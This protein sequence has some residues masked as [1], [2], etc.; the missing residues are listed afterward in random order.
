MLLSGVISLVAQA[1]IPVFEVTDIGI[2]GTTDIRN[3]YG[4][5]VAAADFDQD[6]DID[7]Y[8]A[9]INGVN[10][11]LYRNN[12]SGIFEDVAADVGIDNKASTSMALW[13]DYD[14]DH[15]LDLVTL[16]ERCGNFNCGQPILIKLFS[17][18]DD[19]TFIEVTSEAGLSFG[20]KYD[21]I[22]TS[23]AVGGMAAGDINNDGFLDL[24]VT[25]WGGKITMF[26]NNTD[27]TFTD[28]SES[29]GMG[30]QAWHYWQPMLYDFDHDGLTDIFCNVDFDKNQF[31][32][33]RGNNH[34][35]EIA[36]QIKAAVDFSEMGMTICD[37]DNDGD[38]DIYSTNITRFFEGRDEYNVLLRNDSETGL[39]SFT[40][41]AQSYGVA[42]SGWDW[43][44][45]FIDVN[46]DGWVDLAATNG[47][48]IDPR[49][50][51]D[52]S[53]FWL[54]NNG[55]FTEVTDEIKFN[56]E[57][58][59]TSLIA[60]D[61]DRDG[62]L[63]LL[64]TLKDN[65]DTKMP[66]M[67]YVNTLDQLSNKGNYVVIKPRM[68]GN[69]HFA[70]G[71]V[72]RVQTGELSQ[73]RL[74]SAG[75]SFYAQ[76]PAE[77]FFGMRDYTKADEVRIEWP[78]GEVSIYDDIEANQAITLNYEIVNAP[79][80]L[81]GTFVDDDLVLNWKDRADN[82]TGFLLQKS[83]S[84]DFEEYMEITLGSNTASY[85]DNA[86]DST[87]PYYRIKA[88]NDRVSSPFS[89][90]IHISP[91]TMVEPE[92]EPFFI[93][94]PNPT[95]GHITI[96]LNDPYTGPVDVEIFDASGKEARSVSM[97]K[98][99]TTLK[100]EM[101]LNLEPGVYFVR[102]SASDKS[103]DQRLVIWN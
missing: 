76:E 78:D 13:V 26:L 79:D 34:F 74:I 100:H 6:G 98:P 14:G 59:A 54:N 10:D 97:S 36:V 22:Q 62:D 25:V 99:D 43:G 11:R 87:K 28:I 65:D 90:T 7:F 81:Q 9:T 103:F 20:S 52:Q 4:H 33:N 102:V 89:K 2:T 47:W 16:A 64:Q 72:V 77:A 18:Q 91:Q 96:E 3:F 60:F 27:G 88:F 35:I 17:H 5:G 85:L 86:Y 101:D 21:D 75:T 37:F 48:N 8:L 45:T 61:M 44:A 83:S 82:E 23:L 93:I 29:C 92:P 12:G 51:P 49:W 71:A 31:W 68:S 39:L 84:R 67:A 57:L 95:D 41:V 24:L 32:S 80:S 94:Y 69:N 30:T 15:D 58:S 73:M 46:N 70:I 56:D 38:L 66:A 53:S 63:D 50:G 40:E 19:G 55:S 1:Q 42:N